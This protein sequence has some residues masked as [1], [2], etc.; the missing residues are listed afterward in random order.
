MLLVKRIG[1]RYL[2]VD[3]LCIVQD[4]LSSWE[5]NAKA[6]H[7]VYGNAYFTICA[8]D[9]DATTGLRAL[10]E[11]LS[12]VRTSSTSAS[13][14]TLLRS[15][16]SSSSTENEIM[17]MNDP[18]NNFGDTHEPL[19][20][21]HPVRLLVSRSPEDVIRGSSWDKRG[22]TF[23]ERLLSRRCL[24]F[25]EGR[26]YFQCRSIVMS[27]DKYPDPSQ[28]GWGLDY[29]NSTLR[30][31]GELK[32]KAFWFY[33][34]CVGLYTGRHLTKPKDILT[35]FQGSSW[36][37]N[38]YLKA[39]LLYG[40]PRSH[41]DLAILWTPVS[42]LRRRK[43]RFP[44]GHGASSATTNWDDTCVRCSATS[45]DFGEKDFPSW[46]WCGWMD[47]K[48]EYESK[49]LEGCLPDVQEWL[50][51][52]TWIQ[53]YVRD[54]DGNLRP[55]WD[56]FML[57]E[58]ISEDKRWR[59][60][61]G[62]QTPLNYPIR[63]SAL[64]P[65]RDMART[66][67]SRSASDSQSE[68]S[69]GPTWVDAKIPR[70]RSH[71]TSALPA[72]VR[73]RSSDVETMRPQEKSQGVYPSR[74]RTSQLYS[75]EVD[76]TRLPEESQE[77]YSPRD[78][79]PTR[80]PSDVDKYRLAEEYQAE[81]PPHRR[82]RQRY[83]SEVDR[84]RLSG[85]FQEEYSPRARTPTR[86]SVE[87]GLEYPHSRP[88]PARQV[89][90]P[91]PPVPEPPTD[92]ASMESETDTGIDPYLRKRGMI[93]L[94]DQMRR[95]RGSSTTRS[96]QQSET[97]DIPYVDYYGRPI[98][99]SAK[100]GTKFSSLTPDN[101]FGICCEDFSDETG[102]DDDTAMP[103]LQFWTHRQDLRVEIHEQEDSNRPRN[104]LCKCDIRNSN[105]DVCGVIKLPW[106]YI[107]AHPGQGTFCFIAL[108]DSKGFTEEEMP[109]W[110]FFTMKERE[111]S[112]WDVYFV[113]LLERNDH[114]AL[115]ERVAL[116]KV[117]KAA[118]K[119]STWSEI[120]LG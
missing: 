84:R 38:Q 57:D 106:S 26:A 75:A 33:M 35:A 41:F 103:V 92:R 100:C 58:D 54:R 112:E 72:T 78:R 90:S 3:S 39:P 67:D 34:K 115:W 51:K 91:A 118:F 86:H 43:K 30:T 64:S 88:P 15:H 63:S 71:T 111:D 23:Q 74:P 81:Y 45:A 16:A 113:L 46:S 89:P 77:E 24:V 96:T 76:R 20:I 36:L 50:T 105:D 93:P 22:W 9:G 68:E 8:A 1:L 61:A 47:G 114:R 120:Q 44:R 19:I 60:Y 6:M 4:S 29:A 7:L 56:R 82:T 85:E 21:E 40:L 107:E 37:L 116:G 102:F 18:S 13:S 66:A 25:A 73:R 53:W 83:S 119:G 27:Q 5:L 87:P 42:S 17:R 11:I 48:C 28:R 31:L 98:S 109:D 65:A 10:S 62:Y 55:L 108:S 110:N 104:G 94:G 97:Y 99:L 52:H 70:R 79:A 2:W 59:G 101:P 80:Y 117:F 49:L 95:T 12:N 14:L 69:H 32:K